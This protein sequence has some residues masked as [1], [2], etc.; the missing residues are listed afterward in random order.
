MQLFASTQRDRDRSWLA[1]LL[2]QH[3]IT[4]ARVYC[5]AFTARCVLHFSTCCVLSRSVIIAV[6]L[7]S[8]FALQTLQCRHGVW[9]RTG[10]AVAGRCRPLAAKRESP[11][12]ENGH[13][14]HILIAQNKGRCCA[15]LD[16]FLFSV[17]SVHWV[18]A[19]HACCCA[20]VCTAV[21]LCVEVLCCGS[22][23]GLFRG[24]DNT[25]RVSDNTCPGI[26]AV[27]LGIALRYSCHCST[28]C[29]AVITALQASSLAVAA[30][31]KM[32][33]L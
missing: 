8:L 31:D 21:L 14:G 24:R 16:L 6:C 13:F 20:G 17:D 33:G 18:L 23:S 11:D 30:A 29:S 7:L 2:Q 26:C 4:D 19:C 15:A 32:F 10:A 1:G 25:W 27:C 22:S 12:I 3:P 5:I 28:K 9:L